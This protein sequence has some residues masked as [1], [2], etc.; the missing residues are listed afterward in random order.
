MHFNLVETRLL[1]IKLEAVCV[2]FQRKL[3][4]C[5]CLGAGIFRENAG[6]DGKKLTAALVVV[7]VLYL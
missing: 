6:K 7:S 4:V 5:V 3:C 1:E 2:W